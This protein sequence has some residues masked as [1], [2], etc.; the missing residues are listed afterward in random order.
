MWVPLDFLW[1]SYLLL[2]HRQQLRYFVQ[3]LYIV[4]ILFSKVFHSYLFLLL[5][6]FLVLPSFDSHFVLKSNKHLFVTNHLCKVGK[7]L[8]QL[9]DLPFYFFVFMWHLQKPELW[10]ALAEWWG[11]INT[12]QYFTQMKEK[13]V[14]IDY[15]VI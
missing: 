1:L 15:K 10:L 6:V 4:R 11:S 14:T 3:V 2:G 5:L 12:M 8:F 7:E 9:H 13:N